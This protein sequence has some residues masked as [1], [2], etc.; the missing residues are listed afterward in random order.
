MNVIEAR[1]LTKRYKNTAAVD[2]VTFTAESGEILGILGPNGAGKTTLLSLIST[3]VKPDQGELYFNKEDIIK[4]PKAIQ[5]FLGF[6]PQEIALYEML[7]VKDNMYFWG[8]IYDLSRVQIK[9]RI[10]EVL[11][12]VGL[13]EHINQRVSRLSGGMKRRLNIAASLIHQPQIL[14]MDEPTVGI[15]TESRRYI[16]SAIKN[17]KNKGTIIIYT[18]HY[19]EEAEFLCDRLL[20][21][22]NGKAIALGTINELISILDI[23]SNLAGKEKPRLEEIYLD[24]LKK[25]E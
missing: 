1:N 23:N 12:M 19:I 4:K 24:L 25:Y 10:T 8:G 22:K 11:E 20:I 6:V 7:S 5:P 15:D 14:I 2:G 3:L 9:D 16:I 18:S 13:K 21:M 17:L